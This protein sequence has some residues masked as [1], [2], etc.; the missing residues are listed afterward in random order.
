[1]LTVLAVAL[2]IGL[3]VIMTLELAGAVYPNGGALPMCCRVRR[4]S[5]VRG[6]LLE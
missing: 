1:M 3:A 5:D 2:S 4:H 6:Y